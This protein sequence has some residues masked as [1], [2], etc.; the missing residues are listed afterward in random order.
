MTLISRSGVPYTTAMIGL[1][2][3]GI[4]YVAQDYIGSSQG[5]YNHGWT[6]VAGGFSLLE[7]KNRENT[8][9]KL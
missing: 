3:E 7:M 5:I 6:L 8:L 1:M 9:Y 4:I 2:G